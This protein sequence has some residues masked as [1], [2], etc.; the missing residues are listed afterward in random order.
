MG[1]ALG[2]TNQKSPDHRLV[3]F[4]KTASWVTKVSLLSINL[5]L[6]MAAFIELICN[7]QVLLMLL[8]GIP[9]LILKDFIGV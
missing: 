2:E 3:S 1:K 6:V 5:C 4:K 8:I 7:L 9:N